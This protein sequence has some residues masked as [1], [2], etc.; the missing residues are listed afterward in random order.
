MTK[1]IALANQKGGVGKTTTAINVAAYL[2][3]LGRH[4]LLIDLDPQGNTT[5]GLGYNKSQISN[6]LYEVISN[7]VA[8]ENAIAHTSYSKLDLIAA[9]SNLAGAEVELTRRNGREFVLKKSITNL[10]YDYIL[11]DCPP[12]LGLLTINGLVA[13]DYLLIPTQVEFYALEGLSQLLNTVKRV[14]A[15]LNPKLKLLGVVATMYDSR[16]SLSNA[17]MNELSKHFEKLLFDTRIPRNIRLAEAPSHGK[18]IYA[19]DRFCKGAFAYKK[20]TKEIVNRVE[21]KQ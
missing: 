11:I 6:S 7:A 13:A 10:E 1:V 18:P 20:L 17:V 14:R 4:V 19:Y 12:S 16:M 3:K 8:I 21:T 2:A 5:S 9:N 15:A